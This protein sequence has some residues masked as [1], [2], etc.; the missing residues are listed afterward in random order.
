MLLFFRLCTESS[1]SLLRRL[2]FTAV[3]TG[4]LFTSTWPDDSLIRPRRCDDVVI[5]HYNRA[6]A[7]QLE[8]PHGCCCV[9]AMYRSRVRKYAALQQCVV[10][11]LYTLVLTLRLY[12]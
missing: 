1:P 5:V 4:M 2:I 11:P 7:A 3:E 12:S 10:H 8:R 6:F 9:R